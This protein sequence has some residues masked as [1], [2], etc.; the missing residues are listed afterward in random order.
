MK[1]KGRLR[2]DF[3]QSQR[4]FNRCNT[5][6]FTPSLSAVI[7]TVPVRLL[8]NPGPILLQDSFVR[9]LFLPV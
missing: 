4:P 2:I 1:A 8:Y 5:I 3:R 7:I 9:P 6:R